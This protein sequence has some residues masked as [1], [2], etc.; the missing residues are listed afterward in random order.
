[1]TFTGR[2]TLQGTLPMNS[3]TFRMEVVGIEGVNSGTDVT[4]RVS[5]VGTGIAINT[6]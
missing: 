1:M 6:T 5:A 4:E 2:L 3:G